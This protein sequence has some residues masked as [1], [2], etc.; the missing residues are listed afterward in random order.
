MV[1]GAARGC[2]PSPDAPGTEC[3]HHVDD[4]TGNRLVV[5]GEEHLEAG[6]RLLRRTGLL[7]VFAGAPAVVHRVVAP[8]ADGHAVNRCPVCW[9]VVRL[10]FEHPE[11]RV[12]EVFVGLLLYRSSDLVVLL[13]NVLGF[14]EDR[15]EIGFSHHSTEVRMHLRP[16]AG[17]DRLNQRICREAR[18][19]VALCWSVQQILIDIFSRVSCVS[20]RFRVR[21]RP[22]VWKP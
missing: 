11:D 20:V 19:I 1:V 18:S 16:S 15:R 22:V 21:L 10:A 8:V 12:S 6:T 7:P 4:V 5:V 2:A 9:E 3:A 14:L 17:S 13:G